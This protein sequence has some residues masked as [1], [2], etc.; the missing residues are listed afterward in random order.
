VRHDRDDCSSHTAIGSSSG[1]HFRCKFRTTSSLRRRC[2]MTG[3]G[4]LL[5]EKVDIATPRIQSGSANLAP[6]L[7]TSIAGMCAGADSIDD[8]D[9]VRSG[10][11]RALFDGVYAPRLSE[12]CCGSSP[13][14]MPANSNRCFANIWWRR[15]SGSTCPLRRRGAGVRRHR[16]AAAPGLRARQTGRPLRTHQD[17]RQAD[18]AQGTVPAGDHDQHPGRRTGDR[19]AAATRRAR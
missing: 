6:K 16:F 10:G 11:M 15:A 4:R 17:R 2:S 18:P 8:I 3:L 19:W 1:R 9:L 12:P 5:E 13:S 7:S 14:V